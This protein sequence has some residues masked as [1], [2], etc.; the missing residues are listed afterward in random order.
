[1]TLNATVQIDRSEKRKVVCLGY[2]N[3]ETTQLE[4]ESAG[5]VPIEELQ[6]LLAK[7]CQDYQARGLRIKKDSDAELPQSGREPESR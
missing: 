5:D 1:M 3:P 2:F 6:A 7:F 4:F